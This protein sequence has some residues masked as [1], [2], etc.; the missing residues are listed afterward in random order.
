MVLLQTTYCGFSHRL[1][2]IHWRQRFLHLSVGLTLLHAGLARA[3]R[4]DDTEES[5]NV[6]LI[7]STCAIVLI[8]LVFVWACF[9]R[10]LARRAK[11][12]IPDVNDPEIARAEA[13]LVGTL[14]EAARQNYERAR[15]KI[16]S[17]V[18]LVYCDF[19]FYRDV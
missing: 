15:C 5:K 16:I 4:I 11:N 13:N 3:T 18:G 10:R 19:N 17:H 1:T 7:G 8:C 12:R 9:C 2:N 14:D 6:A